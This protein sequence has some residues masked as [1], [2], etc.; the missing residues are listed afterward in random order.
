MD[1]TN[2]D[3]IL[4]DIIKSLTDFDLIGG[5]A[6]QTHQVSVMNEHKFILTLI[7]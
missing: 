3:P 6:Y 2:A 1:S 5:A 4:F 7:A